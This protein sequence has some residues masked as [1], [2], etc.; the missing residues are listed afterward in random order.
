MVL[1][2]LRS[3]AKNNGCNSPAQLTLRPAV[4]TRPAVLLL[5]A[6][7]SSVCSQLLCLLTGSVWATLTLT[8]NAT[9]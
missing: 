7:N 4:L 6:A 9:Y 5:G 8:F 1:R 2:M 3:E